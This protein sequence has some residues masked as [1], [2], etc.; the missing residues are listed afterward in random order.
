[1]RKILIK[2]KDS[3]TN[4]RKTY[5]SKLADMETEEVTEITLQTA[6]DSKM[7]DC[8]SIQKTKQYITTYNK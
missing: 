5:S 2:K 1:M 8:Y 3:E 4:Q 6:R 7:V